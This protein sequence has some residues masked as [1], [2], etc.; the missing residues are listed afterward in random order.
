MG[1]VSYVSREVS[2]IVFFFFFSFSHSCEL[3][4]LIVI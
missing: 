1:F 2:G 4:T 3:L